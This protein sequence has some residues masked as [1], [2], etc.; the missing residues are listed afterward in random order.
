[1]GMGIAAGISTG[2]GPMLDCMYATCPGL[3]GIAAMYGD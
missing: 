3:A 1:M 2:T